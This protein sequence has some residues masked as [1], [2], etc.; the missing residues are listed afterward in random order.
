MNDR[1]T[2]LIGDLIDMSSDVREWSLNE[3]SRLLKSSSST[4]ATPEEFVNAVSRQPFPE[5]TGFVNSLIGIS[6]DVTSTS[7]PGLAH[8]L[9][10]LQIISLFSQLPENSPSASRTGQPDPDESQANSVADNVTDSVIGNIKNLPEEILT[11]NLAEI[12]SLTLPAAAFS[13]EEM[14]LLPEKIADRLPELIAGAGARPADC[15]AWRGFG[16]ICYDENTPSRDASLLAA[17][18]ALYNNH[19]RP[20]QSLTNHPSAESTTALATLMGHASP[21]TAEKS[22]DTKNIINRLGLS[23]DPL[24]IQLDKSTDLN[25]WNL[26]AKE[27]RPRRDLAL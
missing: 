21:A 3:A 11:G 1:E 15:A 13:R 12:L 22:N 4:R 23:P 5:E 18:E 10:S 20:W 19:I 17:A 7:I 27:I 2:L 16:V 6:R 26:A 25:K 24:I 9:R 14:A 8:F